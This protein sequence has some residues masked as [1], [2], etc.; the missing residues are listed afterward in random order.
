MPGATVSSAPVLTT[1]C[2]SRPVIIAAVKDNTTILL[3]ILLFFMIHPALLTSVLLYG[4]NMIRQMMKNPPPIY[5]LLPNT[6][7]I[8][9]IPI[10]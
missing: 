1:V 10:N 4:K 3:A 2:I 7:K 9:L 5:N 6:K 8:E